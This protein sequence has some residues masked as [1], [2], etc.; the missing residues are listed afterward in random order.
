[1]TTA[2]PQRALLVDDHD[3]ARAWLRGAVLSAFPGLVIE[4][5]TSVASARAALQSAPFDLALLDLGLP[6]GSGLE[7][8]RELRRVRPACL[9]IIATVFDDDEHVFAALKQ[10]A[11]GYLL[12]EQSRDELAVLLAELRQ[13]R[14]PLSTSVARRLLSHF[15]APAPVADQLPALTPRERDVLRMVAKGFSVKETASTLEISPHTAHG[16]VRDIYRKLA[17]SSR[18]EAALAASRMGL[19]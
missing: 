12:K 14:P 3:N 13:G 2:L 15:A 11:N 1:M 6:D 19:L 10:G 5:A 8:L 7:V 17:V 9:C 16:Y 18:A 4:E